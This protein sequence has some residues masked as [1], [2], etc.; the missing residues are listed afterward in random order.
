[1]RKQV[2]DPHK[3]C[4]SFSNTFDNKATRDSK[5]RQQMHKRN[6]MKN[7]NMKHTKTNKLCY[8]SI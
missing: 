1:M 6:I 7:K 8:R 4:T 2:I 3:S 5:S